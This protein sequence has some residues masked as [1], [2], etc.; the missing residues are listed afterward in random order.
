MIQRPEESLPRYASPTPTYVAPPSNR[1]PSTRAP[2]NR[3]P[4][5]ARSDSSRSSSSSRSST[6]SHE[7]SSS[8]A[9]P[10]SYR[11]TIQIPDSDSRPETPPPFHASSPSRYGR[12]PGA[13]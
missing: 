1:E 11:E 4:S 8:F 12:N 10:M 7:S 6:Y 2:S 3:Q 9:S 5:P 13:F